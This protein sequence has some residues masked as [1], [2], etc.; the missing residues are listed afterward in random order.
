MP[1]VF[2]Y[3]THTCLGN[4]VYHCKGVLSLNVNR[5]ILFAR[6]VGFVEILPCASWRQ[7]SGL[8]VVG[9]NTFGGTLLVFLV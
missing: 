2:S 3:N 8:L 9:W 5:C 7:L 4:M 1:C 6:V